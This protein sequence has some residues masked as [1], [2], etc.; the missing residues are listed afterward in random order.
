MKITKIMVSRVFNIGDYQN[1]R[2]GLEIEIED[3]DNETHVILYAI[4]YLVRMNDFLESLRLLRQEWKRLEDKIYK[5]NLITEY[6]TEYQRRLGEIQRKLHCLEDFNKMPA[7]CV[8][9]GNLNIGQ[10]EKEK[11]RLRREIEEI[12]EC[13]DE[14]DK[15][16]SEYHA[17]SNNYEKELRAIIKKAEGGYFLSAT[18]LADD[19]RK[20][21]IDIITKLEKLRPKAFW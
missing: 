17:L 16:E 5:G 1:R 10:L 3:G 19:L 4:D 11:E 12:N 8:D 2:L 18:D 13:L 20:K 14:L 7:A 15:L 21:I 9:I 6:R